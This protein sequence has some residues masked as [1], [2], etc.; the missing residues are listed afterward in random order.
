MWLW[1]AGVLCWRV[2]GGEGHTELYT[3]IEDREKNTETIEISGI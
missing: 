1:S 2:R 3:T